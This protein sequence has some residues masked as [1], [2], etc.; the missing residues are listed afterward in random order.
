[1]IAGR[2]DFAMCYDTL[3]LSD[4]ATSPIVELRWQVERTLN[5]LLQESYGQ[6]L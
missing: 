1:M 3:R 2:W 4:D 6:L 5:V